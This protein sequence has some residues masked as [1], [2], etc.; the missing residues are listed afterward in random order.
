MLYLTLC[1]NKKGRSSSGLSFRQEAI[2]SYVPQMGVEP[3]LALLRTG[4]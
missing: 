3:T 4:F 1:Q 2:P